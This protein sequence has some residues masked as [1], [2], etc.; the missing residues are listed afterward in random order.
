MLK[1]WHGRPV[2]YSVSATGHISATELTTIDEVDLS[3]LG[4]G[5]EASLVVAEAEQR[6]RLLSVVSLD[7]VLEEKI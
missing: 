3:R 4:H 5:L 1:L 2:S 7:G 6:S